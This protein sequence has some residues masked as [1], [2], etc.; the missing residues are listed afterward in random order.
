[1]QKKTLTVL[2]L[3][4]PAVMFLAGCAQGETPVPTASVQGTVPT[5]PS[6][7]TVSSTTSPVPTP[8]A[9]PEG[10]AA[11]VN[12]K[13]ISLEVYQKQ[14]AQFETALRAQGVSLDS[15][16]GQETL[17]QVRRQVLEAL[18]DQA[19]IEQGA[20][21]LGISV[22]ES[23]VSAHVETSLAEGGGRERFLQWLEANA[24]TEEEFRSMVRS[25]LLTNA[26][27][28]HVTSDLPE[29][30]P[31]VRLRQILVSDADLAAQLRERLKR[32][33][34]FAALAERFSEDESSRQQGGD[35]GWFPQGLSLLPP[36]VE[37]ASFALKVG[38]VSEV[39]KAPF[40]YYI[41]QVMEADAAR[42]LSVEMEQSLRQ[43]RFLEWL[44]Q[45]RQ[46]A[47]IE[48]FVDTTH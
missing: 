13:P 19:L 9:A 4:V 47:R 24:M 40:G 22:R 34:S 31:Q 28:D 43:Q 14:V 25:Q 21:A 46:G 17:K 8:E 10:V 16:E 48:R 41:I 37:E 11:R 3:L 29:K 33:E 27:I 38:E 39:I 5:E 23:E 18:I 2:L 7:A 32:G 44:D 36:E 6:P 12:G 30:V 15:A 26:L 35:I 45:Q 1:M 20:E 42:P